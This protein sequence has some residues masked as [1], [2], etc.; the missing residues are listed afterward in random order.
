ML[1]DHKNALAFFQAVSG[2]SSWSFSYRWTQYKEKK[3]T[4]T[5]YCPFIALLAREEKNKDVFFGNFFVWV[6]IFDPTLMQYFIQIPHIIFC[7]PLSAYDKLMMIWAK[8]ITTFSGKVFSSEL[9][10]GPLD[11]NFRSYF[12]FLRHGIEKVMWHLVWKLHKKVQ[13]KSW[14]NVPPKLLACIGFL[15]KVVHNI[16]R[17]WKFN[18]SR[19]IEY[20]F[21]TA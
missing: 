10:A 6:P 11:L 15:Y 20:N 16:G 17:L 7:F 19:E 21:F 5:K 8:K 1:I 2:K 12:T 13:R 9:P 14:S 18:R 3:K 4:A